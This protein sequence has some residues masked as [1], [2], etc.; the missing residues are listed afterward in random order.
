MND[1]SVDTRTNYEIDF[2]TF[3]KNKNYDTS[4]LRTVLFVDST[5]IVN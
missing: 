3:A 1:P 2:Q 4:F 5:C